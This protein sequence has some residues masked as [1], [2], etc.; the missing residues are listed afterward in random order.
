MAR[1]SLIVILI[2]SLL[3][4]LALSLGGF[5]AAPGMLKL[6]GISFSSDTAFLVYVIAWLLLFVSL[7]CSVALWQVY[8]RREYKLTCYLLGFWWIG[9]GIGIYLAFKKPDNLLLD[10]AKGLLIVILTKIS[11]ADAEKVNKFSLALK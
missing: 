9:I 3:A 10:S 6:F 1:K 4:E 8:T 7:V 11:S 5:F 2:F